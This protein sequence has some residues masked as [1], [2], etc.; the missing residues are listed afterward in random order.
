VVDPLGGTA[1]TIKTNIFNGLRAIRC[2][3][4]N[5]AL[6]ALAGADRLDT[7][8]A[9]IFIV[10]CRRADS[11]GGALMNIFNSGQP[12]DYGSPTHAF[13]GAETGDGSVQQAYRAAAL[14]EMAHPG[15]DVPFIYTTWWDGANNRAERSPGSVSDSNVDANAATAF[16][17]DTLYIGR[18]YG[19]QAWRGDYGEMLVYSGELSAPDR[20]A[21][22]AY[23]QDKWG[24]AA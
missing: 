12:E 8:E 17:V 14:T 4:V 5:N 23:L 6:K 13:V 20:A 24:I 15:T 21:V 19:A 9:T 22:Q 2:D 7:N 3:G 1:P 18:R 16:A 11:F 10:G